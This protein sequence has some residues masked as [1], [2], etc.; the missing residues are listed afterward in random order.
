MRGLAAFAA[1]VVVCA[2]A[3][4]DANATAADIARTRIA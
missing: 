3:A 1:G 4:A 2:Y